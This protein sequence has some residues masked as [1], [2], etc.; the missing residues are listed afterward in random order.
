MRNGLTFPTLPNA[1]KGFNN[2]NFVS[3]KYCVIPHKIGGNVND[4]CWQAK[5]KIPTVKLLVTRVGREMVT[6]VGEAEGSRSRQ[7]TRI[8]PPTVI[9]DRSVNDKDTHKDKT[10]TVIRDR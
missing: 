2:S 7:I 3:G 10:K 9:R 5:G 8:D 4:E 1:R 6:R